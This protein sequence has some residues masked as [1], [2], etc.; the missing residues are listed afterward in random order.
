MADNDP[1]EGRVI[2]SG[3]ES[4]KDEFI[5][6][7]TP[8]EIKEL[9]DSGRL[10]EQISLALQGKPSTAKPEDV[11]DFLEGWRRLEGGDADFSKEGPKDS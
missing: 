10:G 11:K 3:D 1:P 2:L 8:E 4:N 7:P 9:E 6:V 5:K